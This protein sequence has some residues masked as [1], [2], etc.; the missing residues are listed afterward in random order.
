MASAPLLDPAS[1]AEVAASFPP[2]LVA[3]KINR[4]IVM[5][6]GWV[7]AI[8]MQLAHPLV[9]AGVADHSAFRSRPGARIERLRSTVRSMLALT[10]GSPHEVARAAA[11]INAIHTRVQGELREGAG[12]LPQGT[13]YSARDPALLRWV[14]A[15]L[16]ST[17]PRAYE[18]Y[19]GPLTQAEKDSFCREGALGSTL[20]GIPHGYLPETAAGIDRYIEDMIADG[21]IAVSETARTV[22]NEV[23]NPPHPP[24]SGPLLSLLRLPVIGLLPESI[25]EAYGFRWERRHAIAMQSSVVATRGILRL[26]PPMVRYWPFAQA[27]I[28]A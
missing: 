16:M 10:F 8:L 2:P 25:R 21:Q 12:A 22:A 28:S 4:E 24:L 9:A 1:L 18:L 23:L 19:V 17:L 26:S 14:H 6:V 15:T 13:R 5:L 11:R 7:P 27:E 3:R 20:L